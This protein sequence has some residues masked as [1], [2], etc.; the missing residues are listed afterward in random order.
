MERITGLILR[1]KPPDGFELD[2]ARAD[3]LSRT[4]IDTLAALHRIDFAAI[5]LGDLGRPEG[6]IERQVNGW[7]ER[8]REAQTDEVAEIDE[9]AAWLAAELPAR[10]VDRRLGPARAALIH[11]DFKYDNMVL[12]PETL[13]VR[14]IL[15]WEMSTVGDPWMDLGT[16]LCYWVEAGDEPGIRGLAF[17]PTAAPGMWTRAQLLDRYR[18][19]TGDEIDRPLFYYV[20]GLF[21]LA[22][23]VQQIY[24]RYVRGH[25]RD[26]RFAAFG[27]AVVMLAR[28]AAQAIECDQV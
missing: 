6:Y 13:E 9:V 16:A 17:G 24:V 14:G 5:G 23:V 26:P 27:H 1:R 28:Q 2:E 25:T 3:T 21:K 19:I 4:L 15:D 12:D 8:Y 18:E 22:G 7:T 11:N 20:F 10:V